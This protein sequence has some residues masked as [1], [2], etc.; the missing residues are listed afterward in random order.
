MQYFAALGKMPGR[1]LFYW[2]EAFVGG[3][4]YTPQSSRSL[5]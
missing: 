4:P 3:G 2:P 1:A 5:V